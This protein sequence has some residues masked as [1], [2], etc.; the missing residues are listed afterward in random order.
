LSG[1]IIPYGEGYPSCFGYKSVDNV[2]WRINMGTS[3]P[4]DPIGIVIDNVVYAT[5]S[6]NT[7]SYKLLIK[8]GAIPLPEELF[9]LMKNIE[10]PE[11]EISF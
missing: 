1:K 9:Y 5:L 4:T 2:I 3:N 10:I 7:Y 11:K 6:P 8:N